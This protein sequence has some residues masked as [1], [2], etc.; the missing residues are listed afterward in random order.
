MNEMKLTEVFFK[1][2]RKGG[3]PGGIVAVTTKTIESEARGQVRGIIKSDDFNPNPNPNHNHNHSHSDNPI[4]KV[5]G[6]IW[7]SKYPLRGSVNRM[8]KKNVIMSHTST[9]H[10]GQF[11]TVRKVADRGMPVPIVAK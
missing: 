11:G 9:V 1:G 4:V 6:A 7:A 3:L 5:A 10:Q 8:S 2:F